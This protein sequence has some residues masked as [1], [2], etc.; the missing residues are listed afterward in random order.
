[1]AR[2]ASLHHRSALTQ[3]TAPVPVHFRR[4]K[5]HPPPCT[6]DSLIFLINYATD[7]RYTLVVSDAGG[8]LASESDDWRTTER[9]RL[10]LASTCSGPNL[11]KTTHE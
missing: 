6:G 9:W 10:G 7:L 3:M 4:A 8:N 5:F 2:S 11:V 1:M